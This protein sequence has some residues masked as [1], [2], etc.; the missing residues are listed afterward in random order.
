MPDAADMK[1]QAKQ[2]QARV[3]SLL[4]IL[5]KQLEPQNASSP[6]SGAVNVSL[7]ANKNKDRSPIKGGEKSKRKRNKDKE[8]KDGD[9]TTDNG[10]RKEKKKNKKKNKDKDKDNE[11]LKKKKKDKKKTK[12]SGEQN[13]TSVDGEINKKKKKKSS[14]TDDDYGDESELDPE[15]FQICKDRM[16]AVKKALKAMNDYGEDGKKRKD[17]H[18][19]RKR[20]F[21]HHL[22][23]IGEHIDQCL[24]EHEKDLTRMREWRNNLWTFVSKFSD[25]KAKKLYKLYRHAS[26]NSGNASDHSNLSNNAASSSAHTHGY[27]QQQHHH[28]QSYHHNY[29]HYGQQPQPNQSSS[30]YHHDRQGPPP[31]GTSGGL[32]PTTGNSSSYYNSYNN[33]S[34][35]GNSGV[36]YKRDSSSSPYGAGGKFAKHSHRD[37]PNFGR[38]GSSGGGS[39]YEARG[40]PDR[41]SSWSQVN[42][43]S[44]NGGRR[45]QLTGPGRGGSVFEYNGINGRRD[46]LSRDREHRDYRDDH[47]DRDRRPP[48]RSDNGSGYNNSGRVPPPPR[49]TW[50][51][52]PLL[53]L[54]GTPAA[55]Q[56]P[57]PPPPSVS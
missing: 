4:K 24:K 14:A 46:S 40:Y 22:I 54:P 53:P 50:N 29:S 56:G 44:S 11:S 1:P 7:K 13:E 6:F 30:H 33:S 21:Q 18:H 35:G 36:G 27:Q 32:A 45:E 20:E 28:H 52:A 15:V 25:Y 2:L 48:Y 3:E 43:R 38:Q 16:R 47:R 9:V 34:P 12:T 55:A 42:G 8:N 37:Y 19:Y 49:P 31:P 23:I 10:N 57:P 5:A 41:G 26:K 39:G 17:G 51:S